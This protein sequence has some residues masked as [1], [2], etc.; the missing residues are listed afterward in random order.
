MQVYYIRVM[1]QLERQIPHCDV[2]NKT[3]YLDSLNMHKKV[4]K[5]DLVD[6]LTYST[7]LMR[8]RAFTYTVASGGWQD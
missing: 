3:A 5:N 1:T 7:S 8:M 6:V 2:E 4:G